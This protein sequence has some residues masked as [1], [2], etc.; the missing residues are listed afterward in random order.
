MI[1]VVLLVMVCLYWGKV[2]MFDVV[3]VCFCYFWWEDF[4]VFVVCFDFVCCLVNFYFV[5]FG[6]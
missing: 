1:E 6:L 4:V 5:C 3:E 2:F